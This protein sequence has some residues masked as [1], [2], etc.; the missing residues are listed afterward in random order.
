MCATKAPFLDGH[1]QQRTPDSATS[2]GSSD[3]ELGHPALPGREVQAATEGEQQQTRGFAV[4]DGEEGRRVDGADDPLPALPSVFGRE[5]GRQCLAL[6]QQAKDRAQ[7]VSSGW[8]KLD[9]GRRADSEAPNRT[10]R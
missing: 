7:V 4:G 1:A 5:R 9:S 8:L 3:D 6:A 10:V 2:E